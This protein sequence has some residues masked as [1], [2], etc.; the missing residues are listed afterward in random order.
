[1]E[2]AAGNILTDIWNQSPYIALPMLFGWGCWLI[3]VKWGKQAIRCINC[4]EKKGKEYW[5][6]LVGNQNSNM[7]YLI[8][9]AD[10][11]ER[12][13]EEQKEINKQI[14][15]VLSEINISMKLSNQAIQN[16]VEEIKFMRIRGE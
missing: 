12:A 13:L 14:I 9:K 15:S 11:T 16:I 2:N 10:N 1:M 7:E 4:E 5:M 6:K 8:K 3:W